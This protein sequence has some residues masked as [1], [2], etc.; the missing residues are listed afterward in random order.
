MFIIRVYVLAKVMRK[1][2]IIVT[3]L[4]KA[5]WHS[6]KYY[7]LCTCYLYKRMEEQL[8]EVLNCRAC[9]RLFNYISGNQICPNCKSGMEQKFQEVRKYLDENPNSSMRDVVENVDVSKRQVEMW[10]REDRIAFSSAEGSEIGCQ[11]CGK[12]I[13]SGKYCKKCA[14]IM[15]ETLSSFYREEKKE[16]I[17]RNSSDGRMRFLE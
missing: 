3:V 2:Y 5:K 13:C 7:L 10:I 8:M 14:G 1:I 9:G 16:A 11:R 12:P 15:K 6:L 4:E 17:K